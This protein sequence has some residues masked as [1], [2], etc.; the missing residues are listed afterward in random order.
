MCLV[1]CLMVS[2]CVLLCRMVCMYIAIAHLSDSRVIFVG[3]ESHVGS[4][5]WRGGDRGAFAAASL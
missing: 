4:R 3:I 1:V 5:G 2:K